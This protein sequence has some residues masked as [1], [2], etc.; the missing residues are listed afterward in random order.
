MNLYTGLENKNIAF[1]TQW[2]ITKFIILLIKILCIL[3]EP[4]KILI[5][6]R[7]IT[8]VIIFRFY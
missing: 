5:N 7:K 3:L 2:Y 6:N 4:L 1:I 8:I